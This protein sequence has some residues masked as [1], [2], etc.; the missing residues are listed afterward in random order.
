[1]L[2]LE[3]TFLLQSMAIKQRAGGHF[4]SSMVLPF[5]SG[6]SS[7]TILGELSVRILVI[8][9]GIAWGMDS[10]INGKQ[11]GI[12]WLGEEDEAMNV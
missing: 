12:F 11:C 8:E 1:M 6:S 5:F 2:N 7:A 9:H 4:A 10:K 3:E